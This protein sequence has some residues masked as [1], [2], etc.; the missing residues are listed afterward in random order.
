MSV[1]TRANFR[2]AALEAAAELF[3]SRDDVSMSEVAEAIGVGRA[4]LY[5]HY[6]SREAL[7]RD[8]TTFAFDDARRALED[9]HLD[10]V[11]VPE[12]FERVFRALVHIGS[13]YAVVTR[14]SVCPPDDEARLAIGTPLRTL[15]ARGQQDGALRADVPDEWLLFALKGAI[16]SAL[17][18]AHTAGVE[19]AAAF[20]ARQ[21][22]HGAR[23]A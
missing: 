13:R 18:L 19:D 15:V 9:A 5:R 8:L 14:E 7:L 23:N 17:E 22:L 16:L 2:R 20:G 11:D 21:F 6:D 1:G 3:A 12:A 4:T 10:E